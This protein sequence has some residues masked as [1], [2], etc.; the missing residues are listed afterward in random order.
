MTNVILGNVHNYTFGNL[1][2]L[3]AE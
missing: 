1:Q 3:G 2:I